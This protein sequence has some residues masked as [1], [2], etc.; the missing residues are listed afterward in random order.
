MKLEF[1]RQIFEKSSN[2]KFNKNPVGPEFFHAD[3]RQTDITKLIVAIRSFAIA[4]SFLPLGATA[5][6]E[7]WPP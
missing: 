3:R 2:I 4:P 7:P 5:L 6:S 1:S